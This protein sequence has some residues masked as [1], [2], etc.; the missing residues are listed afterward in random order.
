MRRMAS[1]T[2]SPAPD[3]VADGL[4]EGA[5]VGSDQL[6]FGG[7]EQSLRG[8]VRVLDHLCADGDF[9]VAHG[10]DRVQLGLRVGRR[11]GEGK[12][13]RRLLTRCG[14]VEVLRRGFDLPVGGRVEGDVSGGVRSVGLH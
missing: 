10:G 3:D 1:G 12:R 14:Q 8:D 13:D 6:R 7:R 5:D 9:T 4:R 11:R 2:S